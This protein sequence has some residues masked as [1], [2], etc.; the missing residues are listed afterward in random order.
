MEI[1]SIGH[2]AEAT[3]MRPHQLKYLLE[4]MNIVP[5]RRLQ[6]GRFRYRYFTENDIDRLVQFMQGGKSD[7]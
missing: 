7:D 3:G 2:V 6:C 1:F 5:D 4:S